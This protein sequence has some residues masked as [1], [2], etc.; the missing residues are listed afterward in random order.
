MN[1]IVERPQLVRAVLR[2]LNM[3]FGDLTP[4]SYLNIPGKVFYVNKQGGTVLEYEEDNEFE[5]TVW[6]DTTLLWSKITNAFHINYN[7]IQSILEVWLKGEPYK[8]EGVAV[9]QARLSLDFDF[10]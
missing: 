7:E 5:P 6:V 10:D 3:N 2:Y 9:S 4:K 1:I 8:F